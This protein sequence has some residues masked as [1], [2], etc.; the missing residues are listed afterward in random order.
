MESGHRII[1]FF[2]EHCSALLTDVSNVLTEVQ[3]KKS[4]RQTTKD[5]FQGVFK[6]LLHKHDTNTEV[7]HPS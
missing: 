7:L 3:A 1:A 4:K 5:V 6:T 2:Q